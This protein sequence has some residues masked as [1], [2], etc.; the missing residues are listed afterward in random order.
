MVGQAGYWLFGNC[1]CVDGSI[2]SENKAILSCKAL[3][4]GQRL[5]RQVYL[6]RGKARTNTHL[7]FLSKAKCWCMMKSLS[8]WLRVFGMKKLM[9]P[10]IV[11]Y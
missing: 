2:V 5:E 9:V 6:E 4:V 3:R 7:H 8:E 10:V 1:T 11:L